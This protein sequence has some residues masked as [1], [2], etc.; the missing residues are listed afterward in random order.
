MPKTQ[1]L[2]DLFMKGVSDQAAKNKESEK[3]KALSGIVKSLS[4]LLGPQAGAPA[5]ETAPGA[6][7]SPQAGPELMPGVNL[8]GA[9]PMGPMSPT[10]VPPSPQIP[11][12]PP[13]M[14][15][16]NM[17]DQVRQGLFPALEGAGDYAPEA[18][19][20]IHQLFGG[21]LFKDHKADLT[22]AGP[23]SRVLG[24][25]GE[26]V[27]DV[28]NR[29]TK[30]SFGVSENGWLTMVDETGV[31][32]ELKGVRPP[33]MV[34]EQMKGETA[35]DVANI[36]GQFQVMS[37]KVRADAQ[38]TV[39][40]IRTTQGAAI[41]S[42]A[43]LYTHLT[44]K[45]LAGEISEE[46]KSVLNHLE[47]VIIKMGGLQMLLE[48]E[49]GKVSNP[50]PWNELPEEERPPPEVKEEYSWWSRLMGMTP[51]GTGHEKPRS[52]LP[53]GTGEV[54]VHP[55]IRKGG[56]AGEPQGAP[57][58]QQVELTIG[59]KKIRGSPPDNW[60]PDYTQ[61][62]LM[63]MDEARK[64]GADPKVLIQRMKEHGWIL[65]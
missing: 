30:P 35:R 25:S 18:V 62:Y 3:R 43:K 60:P 40:N 57:P 63:K 26:V 34:I 61:K 19:Q 1:Q 8:P 2:L 55:A 42:P 39:A 23:G 27:T 4:T 48:A 54:P 5:P 17:M 31:P 53:A 59:G 32:K 22:V 58:K 45:Y 47:P 49:S 46:E 15:G 33:K 44:N 36:R 16:G 13:G 21:E 9:T 28:P 29:P 24:P 14:G 10:G 37:S 38:K 6:P 20:M 11:G 51:G 52:D 56:G 12:A 7:I 50:A 64:S 65:N 41:N